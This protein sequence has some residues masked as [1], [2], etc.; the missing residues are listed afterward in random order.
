MAMDIR[1]RERRPR[2][3]GGGLSGWLNLHRK[4]VFLAPALGFAGLLVAIPAVY[5]TYLSFTDARG[6]L[7][8]DVDFVGLENYIS[9]LT[10][11]ER[12]WPATLRTLVFTV[13]VVGAE[14]V[15]GM[16]IALLLRRPF[17]G[18]RLVRSAIL[19]PLV[20]TPVAV[21]MMWRL[22]FE[23]NIGFA[24]EV[25]KWI[26]LA[27]QGW[28]S[29]SHQALPTVMFIDVWQ[30]TP[31]MTLI[32]LAGLTS[33]PEEPDEAARV[34]GASAFQRL[35]YITVPLL[36]PTI[37]AAVTLRGVDAFKTFDILFATKGPGGGS[38]HEVETLN[39]Y[40]YSEN[41]VYSNY[42]VAGAVLV[43]FFAAVFLLAVQ[44][45]RTRGGNR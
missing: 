21:G 12:F 9:V 24:N 18:E 37:A 15:L 33:L 17:R 38:M 30:W 7:A 2:P 16:G 27:P 43:V 4:W 13:A 10:D 35:S 26:G 11:T 8:A 22:I 25:L 5:T 14:L 44:P 1:R 39:M 3:Y 34:D 45:M 19:L 29:D 40:A 20:A 36:M 41:F 23:P 31:M 6:S 42:G 28:L 32:L